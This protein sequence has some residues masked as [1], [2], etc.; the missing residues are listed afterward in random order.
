[1]IDFD[2]HGPDWKQRL[3]ASAV[4]VCYAS[5]HW[6]RDPFCQRQLAYARTLGKPVY[7][8]TPPDVRVETLPGE[9]VYVVATPEDAAIVVQEIL[10][11]DR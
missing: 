6:Q 8:L 1:M 7:F 10:D 5:V 3:R 11:G 9:H 4:Y 2:T